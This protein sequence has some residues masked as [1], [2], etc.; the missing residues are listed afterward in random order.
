MRLP[1]K[2]ALSKLENPHQLK[3]INFKKYSG[4]RSL[5]L[6]KLEVFTNEKSFGMDIQLSP[7]LIRIH[8][9]QKAF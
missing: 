6:F 9:R 8:E 4:F 1:L 2:L 7:D 5:E 3:C